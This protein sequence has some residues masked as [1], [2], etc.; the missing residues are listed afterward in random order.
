MKTLARISGLTLFATLC[1]LT[2]FGC[3]SPEP[4]T[5]P[6]RPT[7]TAPRPAP[8]LSAKPA[9]EPATVANETKPAAADSAAM[10]EA[11]MSEKA[12]T[13]AALKESPAVP[14]ATETVAMSEKDLVLA[15]VGG[16]PIRAS[17][18][19][20]HWMTRES[21]QVW[22]YFYSLMDERYAE[23]EAERMGITL[24]PAMVDAAVIDVRMVIEEKIEE[25]QPG[26]GFDRYIQGQYNMT[27]ENYMAGIRRNQVR[28]LL[29]ERV[30]RTWLLTQEHAELR[31][32]IVT[33]EELGAKVQDALDAGR[34]FGEVAQ[35]FSEDTTRENGGLM[36]PI[37]RSE[38][39]LLSSIAFGNEV[40][41]VTGPIE[42]NTRL[43]W[44]KTTAF[45][46]PL[47][48][49]WSLIE[50]AVSASLKERELNEYEFLQWKSFIEINYDVDARAFLSLIG[51]A[52]EQP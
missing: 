23:L 13:P 18:L 5:T 2:A 48:G 37:V 22:E 26:V 3:A 44:V 41:G 11:A 12:A 32:I 16:K 17:D 15:T 39:L 24:D 14:E 40:G 36:P 30:V 20:Q 38:Q 27:P 1:A 25:A 34:D 21:R 43:I 19:M 52:P 28:G 4:T 9:A 33:N 45:P 51:E 35:E 47:S 6:P 8:G 10:S 29:L 42:D 31:V 46:K 49:T 7:Y 50:P